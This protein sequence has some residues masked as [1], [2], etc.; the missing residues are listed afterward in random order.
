MATKLIVITGITGNQGASVADVFLGEP[1]WKIRGLTRDP[2]KPSAQSLTAKGIEM[3]AGD[4]D[5]PATLEKAFQGAH[6][7]FAVTDFWQPYFVPANRLKVKPG[8]TMNEFCY[9]LEVQQGKNIAQAAAKVEGLERLVYSSLSDAKKW[10]KGKYTWVYHFDGK[11]KAV[12]YIKEELPELAKKMSVLLVGLYMTHWQAAPFL[13]PQKQSDGTY[14]LSLTANPD[15]P[16]PMINTR[17]DT[18]YF[19]RALVQVPPGKN[20]LAFGS[21]ISWKNFMALWANMLHLPGGVYKQLTIEDVEK[22]AP[23]GLGRELGEGWAFQGEYGYTGGDPTVIHA[24]DLVVEIPTTNIEEYIE[25]EDW[26]SV[27]G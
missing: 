10:S 9:D 2:S 15:T 20:L 14:V 22:F 11:A 18:G 1:S 3:V 24:K 6:A 26:S 4:L 16:M 7:I 23:G 5:H 12:E 8:Q 17:K 21:M 25:N 13:A 27:L 19:V